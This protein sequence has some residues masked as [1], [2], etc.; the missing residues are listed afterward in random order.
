MIYTWAHALI[1]THMW[2]LTHSH[3]HTHNC[4][5]SHFLTENARPRLGRC[6]ALCFLL[7]TLP[8]GYES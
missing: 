4:V 3:T 1:L 2:S 6:L 8:W 7:Q 5:I